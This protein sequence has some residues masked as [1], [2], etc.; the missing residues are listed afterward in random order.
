MYEKSTGSN[1]KFAYLIATS[2][3]MNLTWSQTV[4]LF[5]SNAWNNFLNAVLSLLIV[6][7]QY[8]ETFVMFKMSVSLSC[9]KIISWQCG[10]SNL[11]GSLSTFTFLTGYFNSLSS[12]SSCWDLIGWRKKFNWS[13][14]HWE[15]WRFSFTYFF[16]QNSSS[17]WVALNTAA[18]DFFKDGILNT[19]FTQIRWLF[20]F[21]KFFLISFCCLNVLW[22]KKNSWHTETIFFSRF[23]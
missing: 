8:I 17:P 13:S 20:F 11:N 21:F 23:F 22:M 6:N 12:F 9:L 14:F 16:F 5:N 4:S 3:L 7:F 2:L 15:N 19:N 1:K 18:F 10:G